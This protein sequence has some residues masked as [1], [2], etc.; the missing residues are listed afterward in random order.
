MFLTLLRHAKA[1]SAR[2]DQEDFDRTLE[3]SGRHDA[4]HVARRLQARGRIPDV[5]LTSPAARALETAQAFTAVFG[6]PTILRDERLYLAS[7]HAL[8]E[9]IR[10]RGGT[11]RHLMVVGH[12]PGISELA[13]KLSAERPLGSM[14]TCAAYTLRFDIEDWRKLDWRTGVDVEFDRPMSL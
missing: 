6:S 14:P 13:D 8:L 4:E 12:N 11:A 10:E 9:I 5:M 1:V 3:A 7:S 2:A